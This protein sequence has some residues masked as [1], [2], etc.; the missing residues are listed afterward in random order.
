MKF[1]ILHNTVARARLRNISEYN[2]YSMLRNVK[3]RI[4]VLYIECKG[5]RI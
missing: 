5:F 4:N 1:Y 3:Y 2:L